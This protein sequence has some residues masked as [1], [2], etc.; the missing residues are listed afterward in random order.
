MPG[1][2]ECASVFFTAVAASA[3]AY[4]A[5]MARKEVEEYA[6]L[7]QLEMRPVMSYQRAECSGSGDRIL[8]F[9]NT[10]KGPAQI[11]MVQAKEPLSI[12]IGAPLSV[13][14]GSESYLKVSCSEE[15]WPPQTWLHLSLYYTDIANTCYRSE[16]LL[17]LHTD[18]AN[19]VFET[20]VS[21]DRVEDFEKAKLPCKVRHWN[22]NMELYKCCNIG[23]EWWLE[24]K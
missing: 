18:I 22:S 16:V 12:Q 3:A 17:D 11:R 14:S 1:G 19:R 7:R 20:F 6:K 10:G 4:A 21:F 2:W 23:P 24:N 15:S 9:S 8:R 5:C 13:G